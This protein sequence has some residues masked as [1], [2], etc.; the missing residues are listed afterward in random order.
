M[1]ANS[2]R[3]GTA[4]L[5]MVL[6][7]CAA[8]APTSELAAQSAASIDTARMI[9][10][11]RTLAHDTMEGRR[12]GTTGAERAQAFLR[13]R[14]AELG[15]QPV[16][17]AAGFE[18]TFDFTPR[19][20]TETLRGV[21]FA[22]MVTGTVHPDRYIVVT[23]HY[24]H[25]GVRDGQIYNGADDNA[26]GTAAML[27]MARY[28]ASSPPEHS[29]IFVAF[30]AEEMGL[31]GARAF[32]SAPP[33]PRDRIVL[34]V[35]MDMISRNESNELYAVGTYHYPWLKPALET[36]VA[37]APVRLLFGHDSPGLPPGDDWTNSSDHGPFHQAGIPFLYF[38]VEDHPDYHKPTDTF[39]NIDPAFYQR[40]VET[41]R[42]VLRTLDADM[43]VK[44]EEAEAA[45]VT[46]G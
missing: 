23:A 18:H 1:V 6:A 31:Q 12:T 43:P 33:V 24:D 14:Y 7:A 44:S 21:N 46:A 39:E 22:G 40:A 30:D 19:N 17:D 35:N 10:D 9:D 2:K 38:G 5:A 42:R 8:P 13:G 34:N 20:G 15:V 28:F 4:V 25:L 37:D 27:A 11:V 3:L 26:A 41:I 45:A 32:V 36:L 29:M 16:G